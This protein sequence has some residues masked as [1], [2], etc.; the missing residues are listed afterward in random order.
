M[1]GVVDEVL[2]VATCG[3]L[4]GVKDLDDDD[5]T[6]EKECGCR[7]DD[8]DDDGGGGWLPDEDDSRRN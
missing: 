7:R 8:D 3:R 5:K 2:A 6:G 4:G 1:V